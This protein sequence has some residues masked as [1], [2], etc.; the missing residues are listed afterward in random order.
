M[1]MKYNLDILGT[2]NVVVLVT[3]R[4]KVNR[5]E[6]KKERRRKKASMMLSNFRDGCAPHLLLLMA[7]IHGL[8]LAGVDAWSLHG[9]R[10]VHPFQRHPS[11]SETITKRSTSKTALSIFN[12]NKIPII[13]DWEVESDN[14]IQGVV[15][16]HPTFGDGDNISTSP[17]VGTPGRNKVVTTINGSKYKLGA[18]AAVTSKPA[19][20][21][22]R[23]STSKGTIPISRAQVARREAPPT[24]SSKESSSGSAA[25]SIFVDIFCSECCW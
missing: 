21:R 13:N 24:P 1:T 16:N 23:P 18:P 11:M 20:S 2:V 25:V 5:S 10:G 17:I 7:V 15:S 8:L 12:S 22:R 4:P 6:H 3:S 9:G 19:I 14:C